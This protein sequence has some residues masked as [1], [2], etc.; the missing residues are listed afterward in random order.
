M[1][2]IGNMSYGNKKQIGAMADKRHELKIGEMAPKSY[3]EDK[4]AMQA[5][6]DLAKLVA[7]K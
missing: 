5:H 4:K 7:K 1:K 2:S 6:A 3:K